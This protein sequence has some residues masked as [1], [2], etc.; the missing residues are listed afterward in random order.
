MALQETRKQIVEKTWGKQI[1]PYFFDETK[2]P[3][4]RIA[5][6]GEYTLEEPYTFI[7][8]EP[9]ALSSSN[10]YPIYLIIC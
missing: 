1:G 2:K 6:P 4:V 8:I 5:K 9:Y 7:L 10:G 3:C